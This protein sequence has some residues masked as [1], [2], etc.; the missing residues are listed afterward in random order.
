[1]TALPVAPIIN[2][3]PHLLLK[4]DA[5]VAAPHLRP[6]L[7]LLSHDELVPHSPHTPTSVPAARGG[8][9]WQD[10]RLSRT[11]KLESRAQRKK[12]VGRSNQLSYPSSNFSDASDEGGNA[13][14]V[15]VDRIA[16]YQRSFLHLLRTKEVVYFSALVR[17]AASCCDDNELDRRTIEVNH[18]LS[19]LLLLLL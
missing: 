7:H 10:P 19:L 11:K 2:S 3:L 17:L 16:F 14:L 15:H 12:T 18:A 5:R 4:C 8:K 9:M 6:R 13:F 1:M